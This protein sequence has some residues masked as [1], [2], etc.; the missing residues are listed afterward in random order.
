MDTAIE[1]FD[2]FIKDLRIKYDIEKEAERVALI[3]QRT[4]E[5]V[6]DYAEQQRVTILQCDKVQE[7][8]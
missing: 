7:T 1:V 2:S 4:L 8:E 5:N 6:I 3:R